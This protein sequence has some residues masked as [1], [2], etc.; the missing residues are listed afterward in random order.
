MEEFLL[1]SLETNEHLTNVGEILFWVVTSNQVVMIKIFNYLP[2]LLYIF[3]CFH[4]NMNEFVV[5]AN[6][7]VPF[8]VT[9]QINI[10]VLLLFVLVITLYFLYLFLKLLLKINVLLFL[11]VI[12]ALHYLIFYCILFNFVYWK[13]LQTI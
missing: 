1:F 3:V 12:F 5:F 8:L 2:N 11:L 6:F 7:H 13:F 10:N 9:K 4:W